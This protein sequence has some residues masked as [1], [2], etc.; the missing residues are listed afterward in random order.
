MVRVADVRLE[1]VPCNYCGDSESL[2]LFYGTD[3][4]Y[5]TVP[6]DV[7]CGVVRC[8]TCGLIYLTPRVQ[9]GS[10]G[11][12]YPEDEYYTNR[13]S[14]GAKG[15]LAGLK[16]EVFFAVARQYFGYPPE[17][18]VW[19]SD[20]RLVRSLGAMTFHGLPSKCH[21]IPRHVRGGRLVEFGFGS[22]DFLCRMQE[23]GWECWGVERSARARAAV[24]ARGIKTV[25]AINDVALPDRYFDHVTSYHAIEHVYDPKATFL[26]MYDI[27]KPGGRIFCGVPNFDSLL[28]RVFRSYWD[29]LGVPIHPY[30]F[31]AGSLRKFLETSGFSDIRIRH[32]SLT[33]GIAGSMQWAWNAMLWRLTGQKYVSRR[34]RELKLLNVALTPA[35][36][37]LDCVGLGDCIEATATKD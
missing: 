4:V 14:I 8:R 9:E 20:G 34:L 12:F 26:R 36:K 24:E 15:K 29:N 37:F 17:T 35:V 10:I 13:E 19:G 5:E 27:L 23:L 7:W 25:E 11:L 2:L 6:Q 32:R 28:G 31:E 22:G 16:K 3:R 30:V 1:E 33:V 18:A 21:R